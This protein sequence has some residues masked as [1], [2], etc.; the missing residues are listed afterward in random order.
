[1]YFSSIVATANSLLTCYR[2]QAHSV[3]LC[4]CVCVCVSV[5]LFGSGWNR[6]RNYSIFERKAGG[7]GGGGEQDSKSRGKGASC[8]EECM[9]D[10]I[11]FTTCI[12]RGRE[13]WRG[14]QVR[15]HNS[16][17]IHVHVPHGR[18]CTGGPFCD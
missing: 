1:M 14:G 7:G 12:Y 17:D 10:L 9:P 4:V 15:K 13:G 5:T 3:Y 6:H 11:S 18:M 2:G 8:E 16:N